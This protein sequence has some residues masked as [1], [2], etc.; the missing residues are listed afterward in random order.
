MNKIQYSHQFYS[1]VESTALSSAERVVPLI[2]DIT[3]PKSVVDV[4][5]GSGGWLKIFSEMGCVIHGFDG[6]WVDD[7]QLV[8]PRQNFTRIDL[9]GGIKSETTFDVA[10]SFEVAEHLSE[11]AADEFIASLCKL[12]PVVC[13]SAAIPGQGGTNHLNEQWQSYWIRKFKNHGYEC[14]DAIR[15]KIWHENLVSVHYRQNMFVFAR[16]PINPEMYENLK[17]Y[18]VG[19]RIPD[20]VHPEVLSDKTGPLNNGF[21]K[22]FFGFIPLYIKNRLGKF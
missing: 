16:N 14:F 13:F 3:Q 2:M 10:I 12:A 5:C 11:P 17:G 15:P 7:D 18:E 1:N 20:L 8:I 6:P 19:N 9:E 21:R 22:F 4:G